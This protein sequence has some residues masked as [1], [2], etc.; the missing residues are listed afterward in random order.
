MIDGRQAAR[1]ANAYRTECRWHV[2]LLAAVHPAPPAVPS[3]DPLLLRRFDPA[4]WPCWRYASIGATGNRGCMD[5]TGARIVKLRPAQE[6]LKSMRLRCSRLSRPGCPHQHQGDQAMELTIDAVVTHRRRRRSRSDRRAG[7]D[8]QLRAGLNGGR[9]GRRQAG[10]GRYQTADGVNTASARSPR[11][12]PTCRRAHRNRPAPAGNKP[13]SSIQ[14][15]APLGA[16]HHSSGNARSPTPA[17]PVKR[18]RR[19][20]RP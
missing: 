17:A 10:A 13:A 14:R 1:I 18:R 8:L 9:T 3:D 20:N 12:T 4:G 2:D 15:N 6:T 5:R 7:R 19:I 16:P 11:A